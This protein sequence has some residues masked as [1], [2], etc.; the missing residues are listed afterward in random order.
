MTPL[1]AG[2]PIPSIRWDVVVIGAGAAGLMACLEL[3][4]ELNVLL[5]NRNTS[6]RSSSRWAQGGIAAVTRPEDSM[7]SHAEDTLRAGAGLCDTD[8][9]QL[10]VGEAPNCVKYL[11]KL[12]M[13]FD[14]ED[15]Q[16]ATT[17]E[18]AHSHQRV[19]HVQDRTGRALID[20][21]RERV[22]HRPGLLHRRGIRVTQLWVEQGR[23]CGVQ[24]LDGARLHWIPSRMVVLATG[25]G[26]HLFT[27][28]TN[29]RQACGEGVVLA[30]EAGAVI[31]DLEFVQFHPTAL[32]LPQAPCFLISEA[33]RGEG[34]ILKDA[35]GVSPVAHIPGRDLA[36]RDKVSQALIRSMRKAGDTSILLDLTPIPRAQLVRRFPTILKRCREFGLDPLQQPI[37]VAP[38]AHYWMGGVATD[39]TAATSLP[40]LH[41]VGEVACTGVHGANRLASNSLMEC[42]VFAGQLA[43]VTLPEEPKV[44]IASAWSQQKW[45][46]GPLSGPEET[47]GLVL[48]IDQLRQ[49]CW[50][51]AGVDRSARDL[52]SGLRDLKP[53]IG[54]LWQRPLLGMMRN[55]PKDQCLLLEE[56][57]RQAL[58]L[59]LDLGHRQRASLLLLQSCLFRRESRGGH[60]R[61][62]AP[63]PLSQWRCHTQIQR[64][65]ELSTRPVRS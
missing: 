23:C 56:P 51:A 48:A 62:D 64:D 42:L 14:R 59:L 20:V 6:R 33:V 40:G 25:G 22:E 47:A 19:L 50:L 53:A 5:I 54:D 27:N 17:L 39:L 43:K 29:P 57:T 31:E 46:T 52:K 11:E 15:G 1:P 26:G 28:S 8:A 13:T 63:M 7:A 45:S 30:W 61:Q 3:P 49:L 58:N 21:L 35:R 16:L 18:A 41:A 36:P 12:G 24:V 9:V 38:A 34:A 32:H 10:L 44:A 60:F 65:K 55:Q 2:K 4:L 37:P